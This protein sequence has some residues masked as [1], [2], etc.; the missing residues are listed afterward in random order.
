[1][2]RRLVPYAFSAAAQAHLYLTERHLFEAKNFVRDL[3]IAALAFVF[4]YGL[5]RFSGAPLV[6]WKPA[7]LWLRGAA[8]SVALLCTFFALSRLPDLGG[9]ILSLSRS[10]RHCA[11]VLENTASEAAAV[12]PA[13]HPDRWLFDL[14]SLNLRSR[15]V[16]QLPLPG[17]H[18]VVVWAA[19]KPQGQQALQRLFCKKK[20]A[21]RCKDSEPSFG[22][23]GR[24]SARW[25]SKSPGTSL[26][27]VRAATCT[28]P[29]VAP[30]PRTRHPHTGKPSLSGLGWTSRFRIAFRG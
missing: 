14:P 5:A 12:L 21:A 30:P 15:T 6:L 3:C 7:A 9:R 18:R 2:N 10:P 11:V 16:V 23:R 29:I 26:E 25:S 19:I 28:R 20:N 22:S 4:S 17:R 24:T 8:S 1:M 27:P 13:V